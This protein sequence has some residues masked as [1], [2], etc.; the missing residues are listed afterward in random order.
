MIKNKI[1]L[2]TVLIISVIG[3]TLAQDP[4]YSQYYANRLYLNPAFAGSEICPKLSLNYRTQWP[5]LG[6]NFT[7][8]NASIDGY[9]D[10][11]QGGVGFQV[12][13]DNQG[14]GIITTTG[15]DAQY[16]YTLQVTNTFNLTGGFQ[17]SFYQRVLNWDKLIFPDMIDPLYGVIHA[18]SEIPSDANNVGYFDFSAGA[19][20]YG[21]NYYFGFAVHHLTQPEESF[22][23]SSDAILP[24][25]YTFHFGAKIP[26]Q[27][28]RFK[29]GE[30]AISPNLMY[31]RQLDF[32]QLN[33]GL[34][35]QRREITFGV[36]MRQNLDF[37]YDALI[38]LIGFV[39]EN[40]KISYSYD[41]TVSKLAKET[42][43]A[44]EVSFSYQL[45]CRQK[46]KRW[47]AIKCPR[48]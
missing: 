16:A 23:N 19:L 44:H 37:H 39:Q 18:T 35:L 8:Y 4:H 7:T 33:Y 22:Y 34:Y 29:R 45:P 41:V 28:R 17:A 14:D 25:K 15:L 26:L 31:Q 11:I 43:G 27:N 5:G 2:T 3:S 9:V 36:W 21:R 30:L 12:S 48:F 38:L 46:R 10:A 6:Y 40:L 32:E 24:R 20:G 42:L 47:S 1:L 13:R